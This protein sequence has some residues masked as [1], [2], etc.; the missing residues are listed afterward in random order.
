LSSEALPNYVLENY[1]K[2]VK[3]DLNDW[4]LKN[5]L[6]AICECK[7][8]GIRVFLFKSG[9]SLVISGKLGSVFTPK[10][11]PL[12]FAKVPEF[13]HAPNRMI[14][15]G[16][17]VSHDGL[18]LFDVL[19]VDDRDL[20]S[21][22]LEERRKILDEILKGTGLE[23][24]IF[25]ANSISEIQQLKEEFVSKGFEGILVK[26]PLSRYGQSNSWLKLKRFDTIDC[27][28]V[29]FEDTPEKARTGIAISW[30]IGVIDR[31]GRTVNIGKVGSFL[32][33]VEPKMIRI[34]S[35][36]E[37]RFQQV[38]EDWKLR[39]PFILRVRHDK[40]TNECNMSQLETAAGRKYE[41]K[42]ER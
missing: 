17:Y 21:L 8:D 4:V 28:V 23:V 16:E 32:E 2:A 37:V 10:A 30:F 1:A 41:P 6:P 11:N 26:N 20:R 22:I 36:L 9:S 29:G 5:P 14:L 38:T 24:N 34:G 42:E 35:V 12:A 31:T 18:H 33:R 27:F 19:Q 13:T 39:A 15:D 7:F 3:M 40:P 25:R